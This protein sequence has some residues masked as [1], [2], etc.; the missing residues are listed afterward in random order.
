MK[1]NITDQFLLD[2]YYYLEKGNDVIDFMLKPPTM[3]N[4]LP[5]P[6]NPF[7]K[8]YYQDNNRK[9]FYNL[10]SRLKRKGYIKVKNLENKKAI[11]VTKEGIGKAL[12]A[13]F[14]SGDKKLRKDGKWVMVIFD[15]PEKYRK[16]RNL[17][18]SILNNLGYKVFQQSVWI[19]PYDVSEETEKLLAS[20]SLDSYVK[21]FIIENI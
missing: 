4:Y 7:F 10:I 11:I 12:E 1:L 15:V 9:K 18:R 16:S 5:G 17:L 20:F 19:S 14:S 3:R 21:I 13:R 8:K 2:A 6:K